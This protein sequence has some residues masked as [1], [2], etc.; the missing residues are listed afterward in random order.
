MRLLLEI[1]EEV[2]SAVGASFPIGL[3]MNSTDELEGGLNSLDALTVVSKLDATS[4]DLID[5]SGGTYFPGARSASDSAGTGPYFRKF[6]EHARQKTRIPLMLTGGFKNLNQAVDIVSSGEVDVVGLA[7]A[8]VLHPDLPG[9]WSTG[10]HSHPEFPR[11]SS[12]PEGGVTAWYTMRIV[13]LGEGR[14]LGENLDI[15]KALEV[16]IERDAER[17]KVWNTHFKAT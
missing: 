17:S 5:I 4:L 16:Y 11:F 10:L 8:L 15:H 7:R 6:A 14:G 12:T 1:V 3:K 13:G 9:Q 2:R